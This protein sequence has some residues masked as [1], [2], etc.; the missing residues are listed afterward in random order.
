MT[1]TVD[2]PLTDTIVDPF[3]DDVTPCEGSSHPRGLN[4][5]VADAPG[6]FLLIRPC[7]G[8]AVVQCEPRVLWIKARGIL[9]CS[10]CHVEYPVER[11]RFIPL[12][13]L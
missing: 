7:H 3:L 8:Y 6:K 11:F 2:D 12:D 13:S 5:H 4:G 10:V 1:L 9:Q